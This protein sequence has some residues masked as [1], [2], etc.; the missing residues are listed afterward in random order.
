MSRILES[1]KPE[2][3]FYYFEEIC[4]IPHGSGNTKQISD[5]CV[6]FAKERNLEVIQDSFNNVIIKKAATSGCEDKPVVMLQ[7][8]LDMVTERASWSEH[9]FETDP[10]ELYIE[11][12]YVSAKGTT[13]GGD[14]GIAVAYMLAILEDNT[15][16]H[17]ALECVF[18]V[19]EET[20]LTGAKEIDLSG[21]KAEYLINL[22]SEEEGIFLA[23]CAGGVRL[24]LTL[25]LHR[26]TMTGNCMHI[27][28]DG[29]KGGHSGA[30]IHK[31]R[32]NANM[33]MGRLLFDLK[34]SGLVDYTFVSMEGGQK[35]NAIPRTCYATV[36]TDVE[37]GDFVKVVNE[38][39]AVYQN[40]YQLTDPDM[41]VEVKAEGTME[42]EVLTP[43]SHLKSLFLLN[44][45]PNGVQ[46]MSQAIEGLVETSLNLGILK[47][48]ENELHVDFSIR[49]SIAS[50]KKALVDQLTF[51][52]EFLG[53]SYEAHGDYPG[54]EYKTTSHLRD[55]MT[56][57][58]DE[59][60]E[61]KSKVEAIHA[62]LECGLLLD[63]MP[64]L[65][66]VSMGPDMQD[67]H[68]PEERLSISSVARC[69][70]FLIQV[71]K[72]LGEK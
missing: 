50:K 14:D 16:I 49:S 5:Y 48:E 39:F 31:N 34:D 42:S 68:T 10:L 60:F 20:G 71:L 26:M 66:I 44:Q 21:C 70:D 18:T 15:L 59:M 45:A 29:L 46:S 53:G 6:T 12:D 37:E 41:K 43:A 35:D 47:M 64:A 22:D 36:L 69:Y 57:I 40:E 17:P 8:H 72:D 58:W 11:G 24:N 13:L 52:V 55:V 61:T 27:T 2:R 51:L 38:I 9:N 3:V 28:I 19:D 25:P 67:I 23:S 30:E 62:G 54:W 33:L 7:G 4:N 65:D 63:K 56:R 1:L 32:C